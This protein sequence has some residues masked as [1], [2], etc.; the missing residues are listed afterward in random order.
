MTGHSTNKI[1]GESLLWPDASVEKIELLYEEC[2]VHIREDPGTHKL[3]R[4]VGYVGIHL[5]GFWDETIIEAATLYSEHP[6]IE[7]CERRLKDLPESGSAARAAT[8]NHLLEIVFIDGCKL[9]ICA[10]R[11]RAELINP[12]S[13]SAAI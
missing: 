5:V 12:Q 11:F 9:W 6:F 8:G 2:S 4:C 13:I 10:N 1:D 3:L 7:D